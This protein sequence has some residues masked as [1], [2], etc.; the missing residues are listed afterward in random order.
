MFCIHFSSS[1][2]FSLLYIFLSVIPSLFGNEMGII[3]KIILKKL[4]CQ[5]NII[6]GLNFFLSIKVIQ[7]YNRKLKKRKHFKKMKVTCF[8]IIPR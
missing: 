8:L 3:L 1:I 5:N 4:E 7:V 6:D 2:Y